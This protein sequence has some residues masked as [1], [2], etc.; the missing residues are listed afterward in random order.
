[1]YFRTG[2]IETP[3]N[4]IILAH[5]TDSIISLRLP[6]NIDPTTLFYTIV[7]IRDKF[8]CIREVHLSPVTVLA[9]ISAIEHFVDIL[10][11][12]NDDPIWKVLISNDQNI[13]GQMITSISQIFT[14]MNY[15]MIENVAQSKE[16]INV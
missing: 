11:Y 10:Q 7:H 14:E 5:T 12:S 15:Q 13:V 9:D 4:R 2:S 16:T 6:G 1:L 3:S 8:D